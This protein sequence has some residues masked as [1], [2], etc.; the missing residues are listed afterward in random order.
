MR[1]TPRHR[2]TRT[3]QRYSVR[4]SGK[5]HLMSDCYRGGDT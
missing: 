5:T 3:E 1:F 2:P 4:Q